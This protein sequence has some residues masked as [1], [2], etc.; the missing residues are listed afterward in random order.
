MENGYYLTPGSTV[1]ALEIGNLSVSIQPKLPIKRV[2]YMA[3]YAAD[4]LKPREQRFDFVEARTLA[5]V[6]VRALV[7]AARRAFARGLLH[8]YRTEEESL[9]TIRGRIRIDEQIRRR[10]GVSLPVEVRYDDF[11]DD[12]LPNQLVKAAVARLGRLRICPKS[13]IAL[14]RVDARLEAV[15]LVEYLPDEVP[16]VRFDRLNEH[17]REVVTLARLILRQQTI[18]TKRGRVRAVGFLM[19]MNRVF[20]KFVRRALREELGQSH[21]T[22]PSGKRLPRHVFLD[23]RRRIK[24][25][26]DL[27][28]WEGSTCTFVGDAKYKRIRD[29]R[30]PNPDLYQLF[31][32]ATALNVT[33]GLLIY[34]KGEADEVVHRVR[35]AEK[36]LEIAALDLSKDIES[37]HA[38]ISRLARKVRALRAKSAGGAPPPGSPSDESRGKVGDLP[39]SLAAGAHPVSASGATTTEKRLASGSEDSRKRGA[40]PEF[41]SGPREARVFTENRRI[42]PPRVPPA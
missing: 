25:E 27:S 11:T 32:Y 22:F 19:D 14:A 4:V 10:F 42:P 1:G 35:H 16:E 20:E 6:L 23:E 33:G 26:P 38:G 21:R 31:A 3:S 18:E 41:P 2:L 15:A 37:L 17:Y 13:R 9:H 12:V 40:N 36:R 24:I 8:G 29:D 28:W 39:S 7:D 5:E 30:V 34:A